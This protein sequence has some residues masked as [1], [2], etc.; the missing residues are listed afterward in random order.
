MTLSCLPHI[1]RLLQEINIQHD[2]V[3]S[4]SHYSVQLFCPYYLSEFLKAATYLVV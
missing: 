1:I 2:L 4:A 3:M